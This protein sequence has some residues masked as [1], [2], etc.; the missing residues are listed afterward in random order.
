M[1]SKQPI[2]QIHDPR[3]CWFCRSQPAADT[4][5][6]TLYYVL[7]HK[8][9]FPGYVVKCAKWQVAV[10]RCLLCRKERE[11]SRKAAWGVIALA[12]IVTTIVVA[13]LFRMSG[14]GWAGAITWGCILSLPLAMPV[15]G[16]IMVVSGLIVSVCR[17]KA[18]E[19]ETSLAE[20]YP[21]CRRLVA[22][23]WK[24]QPA[25]PKYSPRVNESANDEG[26]ERWHQDVV[27]K[28]KE[29]QEAYYRETMRRSSGQE[30]E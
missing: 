25:R 11:E 14:E 17:R 3:V 30:K 16:V 29:V 4:E 10:P 5:A 13:A 26:V 23:G 9:G 15:S 12:Y 7:Q 20:D 22:V 19:Q 8:V 18:H 6:V 2:E 27:Q 1:I 24:L 21:L 28:A